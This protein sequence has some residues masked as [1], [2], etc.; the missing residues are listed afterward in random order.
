MKFSVYYDENVVRKLIDKDRLLQ[1]RLKLILTKEKR[2]EKDAYI[3]IFKNE[4]SSDVFRMNKYV[5]L[6]HKN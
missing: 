6:L 1:F 2:T 3:S 4:I 5:E